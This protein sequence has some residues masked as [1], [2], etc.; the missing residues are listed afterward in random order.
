[1]FA[2]YLDVQNMR[3]F[4]LVIKEIRKKLYIYFQK[5]REKVMIINVRYPQRE[6]KHKK[7]V[8]ISGR[9]TKTLP[10]LH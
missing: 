8:F 1:M 3:T 7:K 10:S 9:T 5:T 2:F 6:D 4:I